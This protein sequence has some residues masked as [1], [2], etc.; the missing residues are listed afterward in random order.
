M[1]TKGGDVYIFAQNMTEASTNVK[2]CTVT[3]LQVFLS[4]EGS[5]VLI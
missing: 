4:L 5:V 3:P 2:F 1:A